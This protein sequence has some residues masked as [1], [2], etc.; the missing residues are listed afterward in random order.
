M[1]GMFRLS[2]IT[3][4]R[5]WTEGKDGTTRKGQEEA[6]K[7]QGAADAATRIEEAAVSP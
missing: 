3:A 1:T 2:S 4:G 5:R 6:A 7:R